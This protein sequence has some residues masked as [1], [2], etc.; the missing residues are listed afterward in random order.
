LTKRG[1]NGENRFSVLAKF[2]EIAKKPTTQP[3]TNPAKTNS[4]NQEI[5][6]IADRLKN[7]R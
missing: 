3:Q 1:K 5:K 4:W 6:L 2:Q 7:V